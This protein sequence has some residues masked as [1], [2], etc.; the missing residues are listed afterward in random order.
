MPDTPAANHTNLGGVTAGGTFGVAEKPP[1]DGGSNAET[2]V[3]P[4]PVPSAS[5]VRLYFPQPNDNSSD[6][7]Q[8]FIT[9]AETPWDGGN[10]T[11]YFAARVDASPAIGQ[12]TCLIGASPALCVE[13]RSPSSAGATNP[14]V[15]ELVIDGI[16]VSLF[17]GDS[18][19]RLTEI[20]KSTDESASQH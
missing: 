12:S 15:L 14:A 3:E 19:D 7:D 6:L 5:W 1:T 10:P 13:P 16:H 11:K 8:P 18:L 4:T 2:P 9:V 20:A 17:G